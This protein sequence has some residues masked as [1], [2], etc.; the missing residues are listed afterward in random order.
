MDTDD[1]VPPPI[2]RISRE[3]LQLQRVLDEFRLED[4]D[5]DVDDA[6]PPPIRRL[7]TASLGA[8]L[9][10]SPSESPLISPKR[11]VGLAARTLVLPRSQHLA[12]T[13][14]FNSTALVDQEEI[15]PLPDNS[16]PAPPI[17]STHTPPLPHRSPLRAR[18]D[19]AQGE[20]CLKPKPLKPQRPN[21][22][23]NF[24]HPFKNRPQSQS[25]P[26]PQAS[27]SQ[28]S[29]QPKYANTSSFRNPPRPLSYRNSPR[30]P[31]NL[32]RWSSLETIDSVQTAQGLSR[33]N[34]HEGAESTHTTSTT[35]TSSSE[36][37]YLSFYDDDD[38]EEREDAHYDEDLTAGGISITPPASI[39]P[40]PTTPSDISRP[41]SS[42][43]S[44]IRSASTTTQGS[45]PKRA[46]AVAII[47]KLR[48]KS[49]PEPLL[50]P[51]NLEAEKRGCLDQRSR[52]D[53]SNSTMTISSGRPSE[54][55]FHGF[56]QSSGSQLSVS[57]KDWKSSNFDTTGLSEAEL[58]K[59]RKKGINPA[60]Y[61][62]MKAARK[63]R[64]VSPIG[65]NT[66]I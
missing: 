3:A 14:L 36:R 8:S 62:E 34:S 38:D 66:F 33:E 31:Y 30:M 64:F 15:R 26:A 22:A 23:R 60:L 51:D 24:S 39:M 25:Q 10:N 44:S 50:T 47:K 19:S 57:S 20:E 9:G 53:S 37:R 52:S 32:R 29:S 21:C 12:S 56:S 7:R 46:T 40:L 49:E 43:S 17:D 63:G 13:P 5:F 35:A 65:G 4:G 27:T 11:S 16:N 48:G 54:L 45:G 41:Q 55:A 2:R 1:G 61:A 58:K 59:C 42:A 6:A 28:R 18:L